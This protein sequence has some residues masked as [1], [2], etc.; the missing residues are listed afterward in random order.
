MA[1]VYAYKEW[2]QLPTLADDAV[3]WS[4]SYDGVLMGWRKCMI[5][6]STFQVSEVT[7]ISQTNVQ[8]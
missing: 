7:F 4:F 2:M 6:A 8:C 5:F 1:R 3:V